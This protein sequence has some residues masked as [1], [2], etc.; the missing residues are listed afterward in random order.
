MKCRFALWSQMTYR[1]RNKQTNIQNARAEELSDGKKIGPQT[2][3]CQKWET[4]LLS[5]D[6]FTLSSIIREE[7]EEKRNFFSME[8]NRNILAVSPTRIHLMSSFLFLG[9]MHRTEPKDFWQEHWRRKCRNCRE[10][11]GRLIRAYMLTWFSWC[12]QHGRW[13]RKRYSLFRMARSSQ[14]PYSSCWVVIKD[15]RD[16]LPFSFDPAGR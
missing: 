1:S 13:E 9:G 16:V 5:R 12:T 10:L 3:T 11:R 15:K 8:T 6:S 4:G 7:R 14:S 2:P